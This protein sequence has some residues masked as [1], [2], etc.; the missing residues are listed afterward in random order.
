M[1]MAEGPRIESGERVG[2]YITDVAPTVLH[3]LGVLVPEQMRGDFTL[4]MFDED[5]SFKNE[6]VERLRREWSQPESVV[7][8]AEMEQ[9]HEQLREMGYR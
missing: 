3:M 4:S 9:V 1:L 5:A 7:S 2:P 8:D 6:P